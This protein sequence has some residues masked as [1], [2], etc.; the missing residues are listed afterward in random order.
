MSLIR[1]IGLA[2]LASSAVLTM[3]VASATAQQQR[4]N[5]VD[6][7][8]S[9]SIEAGCHEI[10]RLDPMK[11]I[12]F[13]SCMQQEQDGLATLKEQWHT[14]SATDRTHCLNLTKS[15]ASPSYVELLTCLQTASEAREIQKSLP[16]GDR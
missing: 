12:T 10:E 1:I 6:Q 2:L 7:P 15:G 9:L 14:F 11:R 8:P 16:P 3:A 4:P 5:T 13:E